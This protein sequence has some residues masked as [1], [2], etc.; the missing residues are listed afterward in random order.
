MDKLQNKFAVITGGSSGIGLA[1]AKE[2]IDNGAKV[3]IF[4]RG[5]HALDEA[6]NDLGPNS[7]AELGDVSRL[8][9]LDRLFAETKSRFGGIDILQVNA[10]LVKLAPLADTTEPILMNWLM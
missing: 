8:T 7:Y 5:K 3:V 10:A 9:D 1:T 6:V 4:A 2:M